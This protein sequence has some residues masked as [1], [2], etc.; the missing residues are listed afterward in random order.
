MLLLLGETDSREAGEFLRTYLTPEILQGPVGFVV[1]VIILHTAWGLRRRIYKL[2]GYRRRMLMLGR[3]HRWR[4]R[5]FKLMPAAGIITVVLAIVAIGMSWSNKQGCHK[6]MTAKTV[7]EIEHLLTQTGHGNMYLPVYRIQH[8]KQPV[9]C[10]TDNDS[11]RCSR[12]G[13]G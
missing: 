5:W 13:K 7:G 4:A 9:G 11:Y 3:W 6:L 2:F 8:T 12:Q 1:G 10:K